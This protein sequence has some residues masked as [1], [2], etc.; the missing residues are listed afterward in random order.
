MKTPPT[1]TKYRVTKE[2]CQEQIDKENLVCTRCGG[3]REAIETVDN[4]NNP[5]HWPGCMV[6]EIFNY[7][8]TEDVYKAASIMVD[9]M[10]FTA[11]S[12][13]GYVPKEDEGYPY[14]RESQIQGTVT[15]IHQYLQAAKKIKP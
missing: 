1:I 14:W 2:E 5:T 9:E 7:G 10:H 8:T 3:K 15:I 11:Y 4:G 13:L 12:H 6:C